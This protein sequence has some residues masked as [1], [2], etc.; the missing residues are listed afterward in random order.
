MGFITHKLQHRG[1][2][3]VISIQISIASSRWWLAFLIIIYSLQ[4][5]DCSLRSKV[6]IVLWGK[7]K[8]KSQIW[9]SSS[10]ALFEHVCHKHHI[11]HLIERHVASDFP[12][13]C[14][15]RRWIKMAWYGYLP[16]PIVT[17]TL[18]TLTSP[19]CR[20]LVSLVLFNAASAA[21]A[22]V[23]CD[24]IIISWIVQN[25]NDRFC[26]T[27][28]QQQETGTPPLKLFLMNAMQ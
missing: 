12:C 7:R 22:A 15:Q 13:C 3:S 4:C 26:T 17:Y 18:L 8:L 21:V 1:N 16:L 27:M 10:P 6:V 24:P 28:N 11:M 9:K 19:L 14:S 25:E 20:A 2:R 5:A 23:R